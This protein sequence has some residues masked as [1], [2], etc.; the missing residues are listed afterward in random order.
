MAEALAWVY[1]G[2]RVD[3]YCGC[4]FDADL[5]ADTTGCGYENQDDPQPRVGWEHVVAVT[6]HLDR[7]CWIKP[8]VAPGPDPD[9]NFECGK[10]AELLAMQADLHNI[11]PAL[12]T[13]IAK[14]GA[15]PYGPVRNE[16]RAFGACDFEV[17]KMLSK[18]PVTEPR[19]DVRGDLARTYFYMAWKYR[20]A[21]KVKLSREDY[22]LMLTWSE[23]DP[24]DARERERA[25]RIKAIQGGGNPFVR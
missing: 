3:L 17:E 16:P 15:S 25:C 20:G 13:L 22:Q 7:S 14:R 1:R 10:P 23:Q 6:R 21:W 9:D 4:R 2:H 19:P 5:R 24:V 8:G 11:Q 18:Y 12:A